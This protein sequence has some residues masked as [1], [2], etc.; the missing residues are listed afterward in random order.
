MGDTVNPKSFSSGRRRSLGWIPLGALA[1]CATA[2][3]ASA[4]D[5]TKLPPPSASKV[6]FLRDIKPLLEGSCL[7][8]HG[9]EKPKSKFRLDSREAA[10][11][12][13]SKGIDIIPGQSAK[14]PLIH[15][16]A[17]IAE[18]EDEAMP[19]DGKGEPLSAEQ[20]GRLRAWIDQGVEWPTNALSAPPKLEFSVTPS[21]RFVSVSGNQ[22][23]F[24]ERLWMREGF[25]CGAEEFSLKQK[26]K[27]DETFTAEGR[28]LLDEGDYRIK[29][30]LEKTDV[31]FIRAGYQQY[32]KY[33]NDAG[34]FDPVAGVPA[35]D[36][37]QD[38]HLD[39]GK[40]WIDVGLTLPDWPRIVAGYEYQYKRGSESLLQWG[41][42]VGGGA[43]LKLYPAYEDVREK[44]Q[45]VKLDVTHDIQGVALEDNFR[46]E[47]YDLSTTQHTVGLQSTSAA[48]PAQITL[49]N[50]GDQHFQAANT[51][52]LEKQL[53][54][55]LFASGGYLYSHLDGDAFFNQNTLL[56]PN[57]I[58]SPTPEFPKLWFSNQI[59]LSQESHVFN[60]NALV[61]AWQGLTFTAGVQSEWMRQIGFGNV[62]LDEVELPDPLL[63]T[64]QPAMLQSSLDKA[65]VDETFTLRYTQIPFTVLYADTQFQQESIG[66][67][68]GQIQ[69]EGDDNLGFLRD[70]DASSDLKQY[71]VG[72]NVSPWRAVAFDAHYKH[73]FKRSDYDN[74][75]DQG[76][77][78]AAGEGYPGF[79]RARTIT[80]DQVAAKL[81]VQPASW[82][83]TTFSYE[84][85]STDFQTT[86]DAA[87]DGFASPGGTVLA[88]NYDAHV[89]SANAV[90]TPW[91]RVY[92]SSTLSYSDSRTA[93]P[94]S[95][96]PV[97]V[98]Y[99]GGVYNV[100]S[101][102]NF[103]LDAKNDLRLTHTYSRA[104]YAQSNLGTGVPFGIVYD[105][106]G[107]QAGVTHRFSTNLTGNLQYSFYRYT[108]P[109]SGGANDFTA[110]AVL[111]SFTMRLP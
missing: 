77:L 19:P 21:F 12:G 63:I 69:V 93:S 90:L 7:R 94:T 43:D 104:D 57:A 103:V 5:E 42:V 59:L 99:R 14:S 35:Y 28:V 95:Y 8:C 6:D 50:Q 46:A 29:L 10:L 36:L 86:T 110:H 79:I 91:R 33:F 70:T 30:G 1:C 64:Q 9:P 111:A 87:L 62:R 101:S 47:F 24:R 56:A 16:V 71:R 49:V 34:G 15:F 54:S 23:K 97:I 65:T 68:E 76:P 20:V 83:K 55:W 26:V 37:G 100:L 88:G 41:D 48:T 107:I 96:S 44:V 85:D 22:A 66:E 38:L 39:L 81:V 106:Q 84:I 61:G 92:L 4:V 51:F 25:A 67:A 58:Y 27:E 60:A 18:V 74:F 52:R 75:V 89:Y 2:L 31:G 3:P 102:V 80:T 73:S 11:K 98:N 13:G 53:T 82:L 45:I 108:E 17:R 72:F 109:T 40:A 78:G 105:W 32:R